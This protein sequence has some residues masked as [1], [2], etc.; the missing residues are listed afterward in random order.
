M[1]LCYFKTTIIVSNCCHLSTFLLLNTLIFLTE[2]SDNLVS[3][4]QSTVVVPF[5]LFILNY[6]Y[7]F[8]NSYLSDILNFTIENISL[9]EDHEKAYY[10]GDIGV[11][12]VLRDV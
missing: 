6:F 1:K 12:G 10:P 3:K 4:F 2:M 7:L 9:L 5:L 11:V 8:L